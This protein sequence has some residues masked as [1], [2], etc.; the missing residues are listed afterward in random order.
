MRLR[1]ADLDGINEIVKPNSR[2][3]IPEWSGEPTK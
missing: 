2:K 3:P 1:Q